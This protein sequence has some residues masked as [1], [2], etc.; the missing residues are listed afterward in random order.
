M[1]NLR[2]DPFLCIE[3]CEEHGK[4]N[5]IVEPQ[6]INLKDLKVTFVFY[7]KKCW[8]K[9]GTNCTAWKSTVTTKEFNDIFGF[10]IAQDN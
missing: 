5:F 1:K 8:H 4:T 7:C 10:K 3:E 2:L 6:D 9:Y